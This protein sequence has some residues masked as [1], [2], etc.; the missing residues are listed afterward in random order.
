MTG[1]ILPS[2]LRSGSATSFCT[3]WFL[4][5]FSL[6][7]YVTSNRASHHS[8]QS[9]VARCDRQLTVIC[10]IPTSF[11]LY[12]YYPTSSHSFEA[13][14]GTS[15]TSKP[16]LIALYCLFFLIS[17]GPV[18]F[19]ATLPP[20]GTNPYYDRGWVAGIWFNIHSLLVNPVITAITF[21]ALVPQLHVLRFRPRDGGADPGALSIVGLGVQAVVFAVVAVSW[22]FRFYMPRGT[23]IRAPKTWYQLVGWSAVN[24]GA[25]VVV[26]AVLWIYVK[27]H[28][29][30]ESI[31]SGDVSRDAERAPLLSR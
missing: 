10:L 25:F 31:G 4:A 2:L 6:V 18:I 17:V 16:T 11:G 23:L 27:R 9:S 24:N 7:F 15:R 22:M 28:W 19:D 14:T 3:Y 20:P 29:G 1:S 5:A 26:Q 8:L 13:S 30:L 12:I 21:A